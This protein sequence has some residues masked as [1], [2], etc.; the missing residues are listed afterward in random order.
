MRVV[1]GIGALCAQ[2]D[3]VLLDQYGV[4]HNGAQ[5]LE[6]V[7]SALEQL[8]AAGTPLVVLSNTAKRRAE[9]VAE[10]PRRGFQ[11]EWLAGAVCSGEE[12]HKALQRDW[13]GQRCVFLGWNRDGDAKY[14]RDTDVALATSPE[15]ADCIVA[16][17]PDRLYA[18]GDEAAPVLTG[19]CDSGDVA[20]YAAC[21]DVCARRGV[22]LLCAN[23]DLVS[24]DPQGRALW[25]P[26]TLADAYRARGGRVVDFGKPDASLFA[27]AV[28]RARGARRP[29]TG[30][31]AT[32]N[33]RSAVPAAPRVLH[34]GDSLKHDI[35]GAANAGVDSLFVVDTGIHARDL[36]RG[37]FDDVDRD[38]THPGDDDTTLLQR[39]ERL[40]EE[41]GTPLPTYVISK[42]AW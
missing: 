9:L 31:D 39:I 28:D 37:R 24:V 18:T 42:F 10:L 40:A 26:G 17:G 19:F 5:L 36:G 35:A 14:L 16:H 3:V 2:Y 21:F 20:P 29:T 41:L 25:M 32:T 8:H 12:C 7:A 13:A 1:S 34:V 30:E 6:G 11:A 33:G 22:P 27:A 4:L 15:D 23:P 38:D